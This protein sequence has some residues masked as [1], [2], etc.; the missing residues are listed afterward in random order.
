MAHALTEQELLKFSTG[1]LDSLEFKSSRIFRA[2]MKPG[3]VN[4]SLETV[5]KAVSAMANSG[6]GRIIIGA[7][8][9]TEPGQVVIDGG[10]PWAFKGATIKEWLTNV[11]PPLVDPELHGLNVFPVTPAEV[12]SEIGEGRAV[13]VIEIPDSEDAPHQARDNRYYIRVGAKSKP[14]GNRIVMDIAN[15]RKHPRI[16][17]ML[18][19]TTEALEICL[20]N[21]SKIAASD[22]A[23]QLVFTSMKSKGLS[24]GPMPFSTL[25][26]ALNSCHT[27]E[28]FNDANKDV[29]NQRPLDNYRPLLPNRQMHKTIPVEWDE[30]VSSS[31]TC[32]WEI[33]ADSAATRSGIIMMGDISKLGTWL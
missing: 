33:S 28:I 6:G 18:R 5:A 20:L 21:D 9:E 8:D 23:I 12:G 4:Q 29:L 14:I 22:I 26:W 19:R 32:E 1:E 7:S 31:S 27:V 13:I 15:R 30:D 24:H 2:D 17:M 10:V 3:E 11:I 16:K 25:T